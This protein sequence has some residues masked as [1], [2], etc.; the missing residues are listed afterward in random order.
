MESMKITDITNGD[1]VKVIEGDNEY[2]G[3]VRAVNSI[4]NYCIVFV[5]GD[6]HGSDHDVFIEDI[7]PIR[8]SQ[9]ILEKNGFYFYDAGESIK[10]I[11]AVE[12]GAK[13][14]GHSDTGSTEYD[15]NVWY[16]KALK[17][18]YIN[19]FFVEMF[20]TVKLTARKHVTTKLYFRE[21]DYV[22]E[23]QHAIA[24]CKFNKEIVL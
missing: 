22:H 1:W 15:I 20:R 3:Q 9:E 12:I 23:L 7:Q 14:F 4:T 24:A 17:D 11:G 2:I 6:G 5:G 21:L 10:G 16:H 13:G 8:L 19:T 18:D